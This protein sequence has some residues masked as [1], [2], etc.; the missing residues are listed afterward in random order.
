MKESQ[1]NKNTSSCLFLLS[2][3]VVWE[4]EKKHTPS[5]FS[6]VSAQWPQPLCAGLRFLYVLHTIAV[7]KACS[8]NFTLSPHTWQLRCDWIDQ[9]EGEDNWEVQ[10]LPAH[11]LWLVF[12]AWSQEQCYDFHLTTGTLT[13]PPVTTFLLLHNMHFCICSTVPWFSK[14]ILW[15]AG[16]L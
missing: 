14:Y 1:W 5:S 2:L 10:T 13:G 4:E 8:R 3:G 11:A 16:L 12:L 9:W 6:S 15:F 7:H